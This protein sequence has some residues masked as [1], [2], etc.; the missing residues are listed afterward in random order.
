M[1]K[2]TTVASDKVFSQEH[3]F[4]L[5]LFTS[6]QIRTHDILNGKHRPWR[7]VTTTTFDKF[8]NC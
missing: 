3:I 2:N 4:V 7:Y 8:K 5:Y 6:T 1:S